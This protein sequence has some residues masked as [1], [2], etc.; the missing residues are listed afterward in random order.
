MTEE[1]IL[2]PLTNDFIAHLQKQGKTQNTLK[3]YRTDLDCYKNYLEVNQ[4][5]NH[6]I[7][8]E[9]SHVLDY[10]K[11]LQLKYNSDNS[12]RRRVQ[13]LRLFFD[14][15]LIKGLVKENPV[16]KIPSSPKFVDVP[17]PITFNE[18]LKWWRLLKLNMNQQALNSRQQSSL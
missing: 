9:L 2:T 13:T 4:N 7:N 1:L 16:R 14:F 17:K 8:P 18:V 15:L 12:R 5:R 6:V 3:N 10:G 11:F